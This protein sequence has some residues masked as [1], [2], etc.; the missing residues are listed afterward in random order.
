MIRSNRTAQLRQ[1]HASRRVLRSNDAC[2]LC[3]VSVPMGSTIIGQTGCLAKAN[4]QLSRAVG[5]QFRPVPPIPGFAI[6]TYTARYGRYIPVC[7]VTG[8]WTARYRAVPPKIVRRRLIE[9]EISRWRSIAGEIDCWRLIE[10]EKGKKKKRKRREER[11]PRR[12]RPRA[13]AAHR[14]P[15]CHHRPRVARVPSPPTGRPRAVAARGRFFSHARRWNVSP[16]R[17]KDRGDVAP[18]LF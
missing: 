17:E 6:S 4:E 8:T 1:R 3:L 10:E 18:F 9:G 11:I 14:S 12:P 13:I 2:G 16:R 5:L 15:A 7:Q